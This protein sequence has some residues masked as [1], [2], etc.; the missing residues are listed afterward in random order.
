MFWTLLAIAV[1]GALGCLARYGV[2]LVV[3]GTLGGGFP[4]A[5]LFINVVG[6]FLMGFLLIL[7]IERLTIGPHLRAGIL[8]GFLGGF[9]TFST[10]AL[11]T[12]LLAEQGSPG[13]SVLYVALSTMI[14]VFAAFAGAYI[15]RLL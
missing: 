14:G 9:T 7:T 5:T 12:V 13:K 15:G 8:T 2:T 11:E 4:Y 10:Y 6:A 3:K 1:F